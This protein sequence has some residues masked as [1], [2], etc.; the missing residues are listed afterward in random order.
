MESYVKNEWGYSIFMSGLT[1]NKR[2]VMALLNNNFQHEVG[3]IIKDPNGNF[4]IMEITMKG[5]KVTLVNIYGPNEDR[6]Q[7]YSNI[8]QRI[9]ELENKMAII[10]GDWNLIID[11][12]L[13]CENYKHV[14]NP[15]ARA[16][17]KDFL[18]DMEFIDAYRLINEEKKVLLG[19]N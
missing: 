9:D 18:D 3:K 10:C 16:V 12:E 8:K 19:E 7:F 15:R 6:P 13:D 1:N 17:V 4:L 11:P 5:K 14:N 2:G